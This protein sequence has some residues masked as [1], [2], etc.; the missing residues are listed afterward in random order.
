MDK[1]E[2]DDGSVSFTESIPDGP[3]CPECG[4]NHEPN[5][6]GTTILVDLP[7]LRLEGTD[8]TPTDDDGPEELRAKLN[9]AI[10]ERAAAGRV[11]N[12]VFHKGKAMA[13]MA[14]LVVGGLREQL[15]RANSVIGKSADAMNLIGT[16]LRGAKARITA[17]ISEN[18]S[19]CLDDAEDRAAVTEA[20]TKAMLR[21]SQEDK[22]KGLAILE[23]LGGLAGSEYDDDAGVPL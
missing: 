6:Y 18:S 23:S 5:Q 4:E 8:V 9:V 14:D 7:D 16:V 12:D 3:A 19:R 10:R 11:I 22:A 13:K 21:V 1:H 17:A 15:Q 20:V 2:H